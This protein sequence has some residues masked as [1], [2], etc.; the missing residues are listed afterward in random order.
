MPITTNASTGYEAYA[1]MADMR[2][3]IVNATELNA[4]DP[5]RV[6]AEANKFILEKREVEKGKKKQTIIVK[7]LNENSYAGATTYDF[8]L[9]INSIYK[10]AQALITEKYKESPNVLTVKLGELKSQQAAVLDALR[11]RCAT[12][13]ESMSTEEKRIKTINLAKELIT[14]FIYN[15]IIIINP[16]A[17]KSENTLKTTSKELQKKES[18]LIAKEGRPNLVNLYPINTTTRYSAERVIGDAIPCSKR[19]QAKLPNFAEHEMGYLDGTNYIPQA[20]LYR[21][22]S[23]TPIGIKAD[24]VRQQA[25]AQC[26]KEYITEIAKQYI[27]STKSSD[28]NATIELKLSSLSLLSPIGPERSVLNAKGMIDDVNLNEEEMLQLKE[29]Y[30]AL[31]MYNGREIEL[32]L[33]DQNGKK[34]KVLPTINFMNSAS[35]AHGVSISNTKT[36]RFNP[37]SQT[38]LE[39]NINTQGMNQFITDVEQYLNNNHS[40]CNRTFKDCF[41]QHLE[42]YVGTKTHTS[43]LK[44]TLNEDLKNLTELKE[45]LSRTFANLEAKKKPTKFKE[46]KQQIEKQ[47]TDIYQLE[48]SMLKKRLAWFESNRTKIA[49]LIDRIIVQKAE[50]K[51]KLIQTP[52]NTTLQQTIKDLEIAELYYQSVL[53]YND[54]TI[55]PNHS[56]V[57]YLLAY[58]L[59]GRS[60]NTFCKSG[61]DRTGRMANLMEEFCQFS[62]INGHFPKY[63]IKLKC[64]DKTDDTKRQSIA[65]QVDQGS[66]SR[67][68]AGQ[69]TLGTGGLQIADEIRA[70]GRQWFNLPLNK[71][72]PNKSGDA[73]GKLAKGVFAFSALNKLRVQSA[74][75]TD[76]HMAPYY[77]P[78]QPV[79]RVTK[80]PR[81]WPKL[82]SNY[83]TALDKKTYLSNEESSLLKPFSRDEQNRLVEKYSKSAKT[84]T[85]SSPKTAYKIALLAT[86]LEHGHKKTQDK[87]NKLAGF[88]QEAA[89]LSGGSRITAGSAD[90]FRKSF[91][92]FDLTLFTKFETNSGV[93]IT[94]SRDRSQITLPP[95]RKNR[96]FYNDP[97]NNVDAT[98]MTLVLTEKAQA[99]GRKDK[100]GEITMNIEEK[101]P[102]QAYLLA[103][104][105]YESCR[106]NG[107]EA[108]KI[109]ILI[110]GLRVSLSPVLKGP[111]LGRRNEKNG[112]EKRANYAAAVNI[113]ATMASKHAVASA[114][115]PTAAAAATPT[116]AA[117]ATLTATAAATPTAAAAATLTATSA[118]TPTAAAAATLTATS[119][120]TP[121]VTSAATPTVT[122][123]ATPTAAAAAKPSAA[124][125][126][127]PAVATTNT[128]LTKVGQIVDQ[129]NNAP[130]KYPE[131]H[132]KE[133]EQRQHAF[134]AVFEQIT[135]NKNN[136]DNS[137]KSDN[138]PTGNG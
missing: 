74:A 131:Q 107:Y 118:A 135:S 20:N 97:K 12:T 15:S 59:M 16:E 125:D 17:I 75:A 134:K 11:E 102:E 23:F 138:T 31:M 123:A 34:Y 39:K 94:T 5:A 14:T 119:A 2:N 115:T 99:E 128:A 45:A 116:A 7:T 126:A 38:T 70:F 92:K 113:G 27:A 1:T 21:S 93:I 62:L 100:S 73:Q 98:M 67:D 120:A 109:T 86:L 50:L 8:E 64:L 66:I 49:T 77:E 37:L 9:R 114:A 51:T 56:G 40:L 72:L 18:E 44:N 80:T 132:S 13:P 52:Q 33:T 47:Q 90:S 103:R 95:Y 87:I 4:N 54:A 133:I 117:A 111:F 29:S 25:A 19:D 41:T 129:I 82:M 30:D 26:T 83:F 112:I 53:I 122:S 55:E 63:D 28:A 68:M 3:D 136:V 81:E 121:T 88:S 36:N 96:K 58:N 43:S 84:K 6:N 124:P 127:K 24:F 78:D 106:M 10:T 137:N 85:E 79:E 57:R 101:N 32:E 91:D 69:N 35:N 48:N 42:G 65:Q 108:D 22:S 110:H 60:V 46:L 130:Q 105:A 89:P 104:K 71:N 76:D 61:K